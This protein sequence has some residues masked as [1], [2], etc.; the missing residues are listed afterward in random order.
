MESP[1][2]NKMLWIVFAI[3][4]IL[5]ACS[6][7]HHVPWNDELH[8]WN[9]AKSSTNYTVMLANS[10][11][12]GHP[13]GWYSLLWMISLFTHKI[14][15]MQA[16]EWAIA[17]SVVFM[18]LFYSP[19]PTLIKVLVPFGY[20][21]VF[22]YAVFSRN[23]S[24][25][26]LLVC[27]I[28]LIIRRHFRFQP[29]LYYL[30]LFSLFNVH[31]IAMLLACSLHV[32][33]LLLQNERQNQKGRL[34]MDAGIGVLFLSLALWSVYPPADSSLHGGT[35]NSLQL[36]RYCLY[37]PLRGFLPIPAW[38]TYHFWNTEMLLD[39]AKTHGTLQWLNPLISVALLASALFLLWPNRKCL[40]LFGTNLLFSGLL[41][42]A[43]F[44]LT[45]ARYAGFLYIG[46]IA[47]LWLFYYENELTVQKRWLTVILL[48]FQV[49]AGFFAVY[50]TFRL[51]FSTLDQ[52]PAM[53][54]KIPAGQ[55]LVSDYWTMESY[56]AFMDKP[57]YCVDL[58]KEKSFIIWNSEM[59][60]M[61]KE[62]YRYSSGLSSL[63]RKERI[64][65]AYMISMHYPA[66]LSELDS[67]LTLSF[68]VD[69]ID[70]KEGAIE[71]GSNLYLY[72]ISEKYAIPDQP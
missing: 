39:A 34:L 31:L 45:T 53:M 9:I 71:Q 60:A 68:H 62:P 49:V 17:S 21:F 36:I 37:P 1:L 65:N 67:Q 69:L 44:S 10:R 43:G 35:Q 63:F 16:L 47:A 26:V 20:Y 38:W 32:Y 66:E 14:A 27:C 52:I 64:S 58:Q 11:Y 5:S 28:C 12:E 61:L 56:A 15:W 57:I 23:Y 7:A 25:G 42:I 2:K 19:L 8:S 3:Y 70:K 18:I 40:A 46:F 30:L 6:M 50:Q 4:A 48:C 29:I 41:S 13:P 54:A 55:K 72:K 59:A 51:P 33:Y 24:M 22:E